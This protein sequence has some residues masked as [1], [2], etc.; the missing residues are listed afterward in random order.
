MGP[1]SGGT[2]AP[3]ASENVTINTSAARPAASEATL[4]L[5]VTPQIPAGGTVSV[6]LKNDSG[7]QIKGELEYDASR[8]TPAQPL[9]NATPGR[10]PVELPP[11]GERV[12]VLRALPSAAGQ[13]LGISVGSLSASG[14]NGESAAVRVDG[15][16]LLTVD[17]A[18]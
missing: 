4:K 17:A 11:R 3:A 12:V 7:L 15:T 8:L 1:S 18:K 9:V 5:E 13:V 2:A 6:A 16:G 14:L 10:Y